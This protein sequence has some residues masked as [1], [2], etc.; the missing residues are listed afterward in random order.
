MQPSFLIFHY[1]FALLPG[2]MKAYE[3]AASNLSMVTDEPCTGREFEFGIFEALELRIFRTM[4]YK[5]FNVNPRF[6]LE[7]IRQ[8]WM[9]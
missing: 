6:S 1:S 5:N 4:E 9:M 7:M 3:I 2:A 8:G